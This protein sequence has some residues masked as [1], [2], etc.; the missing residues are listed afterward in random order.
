MNRLKRV[1]DILAVGKLAYS[2][3]SVWV[4]AWVIPWV[5]VMWEVKGQEL[6]PDAPLLTGWKGV[7]ALM[8][9]WGHMDASR[10]A[11]VVMAGV[12]II[13]LFLVWFRKERDKTGVDKA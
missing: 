1:W 12:T 13:L 9:R 4:V 2:M 6:L 7:V 8:Y 11:Q 5:I 10:V 3:L